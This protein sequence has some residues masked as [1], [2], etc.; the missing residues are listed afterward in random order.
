MLIN[1]HKDVLDSEQ[2]YEQDKLRL[3]SL[4]KYVNY[5]YRLCY[6]IARNK[7]TD[8]EREKNSCSKGMI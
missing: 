5:I 6:Y 1:K 2:K 7:N 8:R 3:N 4:P